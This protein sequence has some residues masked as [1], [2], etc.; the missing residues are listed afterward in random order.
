MAVASAPRLLVLHALRLKGF[1]DTDVVAHAAGVDHDAASNVLAGLA[2]SELVVRRDGKLTGWSLTKAGRSAHA[3]LVAEEL[4]ATGQRAAV[5]DAYHR[6]LA[7][8]GEMLALCTDWQLR[9]QEGAQVVNDHTDPAWDASV[10]ARLGDVDSRIRPSLGDLA[11]VLERFRGYGERFGA[12]LTRV[13]TGELEWFTRPVID[14]YHTVW[15]ELH[16]DL[17]CTLGLERSSEHGQPTT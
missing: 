9:G 6:F 13:R 12:A 4:A 7:V 16:E 3:E 11:G 10:L 15:F 8:N 14:S 5:D 2:G 17:L 1:A